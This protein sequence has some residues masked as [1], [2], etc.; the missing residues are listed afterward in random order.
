M[1]EQPRSLDKR[2]FSALR[3]LA[4][5]AARNAEERCDLC[6]APIG[7]AHRHI[8]N[9]STTEM[10]C[11][12]QACTILFDRPAAGGRTRRLVPT[13]YMQLA[14]FDMTDSQWESLRIPV[15][16]AFFVNNTTAGRVTALYPG[17]A[18]PTESL[19]TL[20]TWED[21]EKRNPVL[22]GMEPDVEALLVNRVREARDYFLVPI[23]ECYRLVGLI[24]VNWR[25]LSGGRVVWQEIERFFAGLKTQA[26]PVGGADA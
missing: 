26:R 12:C 6:N 22:T 17:P 19:L 11:A 4:R 21:L 25:G 18:G 10:L 7:T 2:P 20:E 5:E 8:L 9:V 1:S 14:A 23:D 13:R 3:Q 16:M 15:N 24:R